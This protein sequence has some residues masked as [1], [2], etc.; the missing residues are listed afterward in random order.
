MGYGDKLRGRNGVVI[1]E[2]VVDLLEVPLVFPGAGIER[3]NTVGEEIGTLAVCAIE[4]IGS[5]AKREI[6]DTL[7][8]IKG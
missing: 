5:G 3:Q 4:I 2:I 8:V 7:L 6:H 1:P